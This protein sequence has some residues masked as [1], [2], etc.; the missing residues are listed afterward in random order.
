[1]IN[2]KRLHPASWYRNRKMNSEKETVS[3]EEE[4]AWQEKEADLDSANQQFDSLSDNRENAIN[5]MMVAFIESDLEPS[6]NKVRWLCECL[7]DA[8]YRKQSKLQKG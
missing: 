6:G 3:Q 2:D 1:M 4:Q 5:E 7:Y 8:G